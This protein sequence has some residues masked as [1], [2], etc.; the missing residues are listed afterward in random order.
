M[1]ATGVDLQRAVGRGPAREACLRAVHAFAE[2][3]ALVGGPSWG[4][5]CAAPSGT[6]AVE[7]V[8]AACV[9]RGVVLPGLP[10]ALQVLGAL[11][12]GM[13]LGWAPDGRA[14]SG[15]WEANGWGF[16]RALARPDV[17]V[18][19]GPGGLGDPALDGAAWTGVGRA[20]WY[21]EAGHPGRI[22]RWA[23]GRP[24]AVW[25]GIGQASGFT[26]GGSD[27][28]LEGLAASA[29]ASADLLRQGRAEAMG[30]LRAATG[31]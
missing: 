30:A 1:D 14:P 13:G 17:V 19:R 22:P 11:G 8:A 27:A 20:L 16:A 26:G 6:F 31:T 9:L 18:V 29:G 15:P 21:L 2:G 28:D 4:A 25:R 5:W 7:G 23:S 24:S 10:D 3:M 12:T